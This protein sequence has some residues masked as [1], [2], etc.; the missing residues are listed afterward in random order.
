VKELLA[1][2]GPEFRQADI[3][4]VEDGVW[5]VQLGQETYI[6]KHRTARSRVWEEYDLLNWLT[7]QGQPISP[8][9]FT[10][11][12]TP[13]AEYQLGIYVLY[14]FVEGTPGD[15]LGG[16]TAAFAREAGA[17]LARLHRVLAEYPAGDSFPVFDLFQEAASY[18]WPA[19]QSHAALKFGH[20]LHPLKEA[21]GGELVNPYEAL[22]RQLIHRD[23]HPGNLIFRDG[24]IVGI[25]DF[26]R[27]RLGIRLFD[28]CYLATAVL[29]G[30][31]D[32]P[33]RRREWLGFVRELIV[34]YCSVE[35][36]TRT[37]GFAFLH[38]IYLIQLL[39]IA[40][41]LD[42]GS[43][44]LADKNMAMLLWIHE[45]QDFFRPIIEK[46]VAG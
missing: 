37:E 14:R 41:Y 36:L 15:K 9:L 43:T 40:H 22:P 45:Q 46:L 30:E 23:F 33:Q 29:S 6:L 19:V 25:L 10:K 21:I 28:L 3:T 11:E 42:L 35:P 12:E 4:S 5:R 38:I 8:L 7:A 34:G 16:Y 2:W 24:R 27:V 17:T 1:K 31:F 39:F 32:R 26:D 44:S 18:A 13:W 20:S